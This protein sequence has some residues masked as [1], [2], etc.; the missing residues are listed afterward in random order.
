M[1]KFHT[2][3]G[4]FSS[5]TSTWALTFFA[6]NPSISVGD[7]FCARL[8]STVQ[9]VWVETVES[10]GFYIDLWKFIHRSLALMCLA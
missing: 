4:D 2:T 8:F 9:K 1:I 7:V 6:S 5:A 10:L 3:F